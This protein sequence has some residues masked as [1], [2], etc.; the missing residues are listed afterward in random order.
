[1]FDAGKDVEVWK[2]LN[3]CDEYENRQSISEKLVGLSL[4]HYLLYLCSSSSKIN[5]PQ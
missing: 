1:M 2:L 5:Q 4:T 3:I